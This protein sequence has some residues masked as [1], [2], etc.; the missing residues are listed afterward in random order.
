MGELRF[1]TVNPNP[2]IKAEDSQVTEIQENRLH[3]LVTYS[4]QNGFDE[5][6]YL[7]A[8]EHGLGKSYLLLAELF[9]VTLEMRVSDE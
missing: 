6:F 2:F 3:Y 4:L 9:G 5:D 1:L 7:R 8:E